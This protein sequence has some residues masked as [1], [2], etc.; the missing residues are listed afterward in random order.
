MGSRINRITIIFIFAD[1]RPRV[2]KIDFLVD[3]VAHMIIPHSYGSDFAR[4]D[5]LVGLL[6]DIL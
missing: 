3:T 2:K 5:Q 4:G 6:T 1:L